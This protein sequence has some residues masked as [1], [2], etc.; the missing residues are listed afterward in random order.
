MAAA[1]QARVTAHPRIIKHE[2]EPG[3]TVALMT[4]DP[5][6]FSVQVSRWDS[7]EEALKLPQQP[8]SMIR[9]PHED[10]LQCRVR[11]AH[12]LREKTMATIANIK[13]P[14]LR[15]YHLSH[16]ELWKE[17]HAAEGSKEE[18]ILAIGRSGHWKP[19]SPLPETF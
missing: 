6:P 15:D 16:L 19:L 3:G 12:G 9:Q 7:L 18:T 8:I 10:W 14:L 5:Q 1:V 11:R 2:L 17:V 13:D 4:F